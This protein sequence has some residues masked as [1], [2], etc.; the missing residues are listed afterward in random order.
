MFK[1]ALQSNPLLGAP[2]SHGWVLKDGRY[3]IKWYDGPTLPP[4][5]V[6]MMDDEVICDS[7]LSQS[8]GYDY[9]LEVGSKYGGCTSDEERNDDDNDS[10]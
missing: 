5:I 6:D 2:E 3:T 8:H 4:T 1:H 10:L 9:D 7:E